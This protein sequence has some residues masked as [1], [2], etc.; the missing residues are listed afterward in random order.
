[1][2]D[3]P[4]F[5]IPIRDKDATIPRSAFQTTAHPVV[6]AHPRTGRLQLFVN[7]GLTS[8][9][10]GM[11]DARGED[12]LQEL[13]TILYSDNHIYEHRYSDGDVVV[14]DNVA[15]QHARDQERPN[16]QRRLRRV[17][18]LER[19]IAECQQF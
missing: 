7:E 19:P 2:N 6:M 4:L 3:D 16:S 9:I 17:T 11:D 12:I 14:W 13:F 15:M 1:V 18:V 10:V 8:H 5:R